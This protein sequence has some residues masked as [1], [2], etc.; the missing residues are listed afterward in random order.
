MNSR[1]LALLGLIL[2][3][4]AVFFAFDLGQY[5]ELSTLKAQQAALQAQVAARPW[6]AAGLFFLVYVAVAALSLP[7][8][9]LLTLLAGALFGLL[10]GLLLVSFASTLGATLAMLGS[11]FVLR[12]WVR[13]RFGRRLARIDAGIARDGAFY[14]F[15]LRLVPLFPFFLVNLAMGLTRLPLRTYWWVSQLGML[16][17]TLVYLNAGREL[18]R[19]ES[20]AGILSPG[21]LGAFALLG[22]FP[23]L[24]R[25]LLDLIEAR[26]SRRRG[27]AGDGIQPRSD[28]D[29]R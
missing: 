28:R 13:R 24:A 11:R 18:G 9:A 4:L 23:L 25:R 22:L 21:L 14:L 19:L 27:H 1:K 29:P 5:F 17:G 3:L 26:R 12:D 16:P 10:Q 6:S 8:A 15:A 7:V 2:A 20:L